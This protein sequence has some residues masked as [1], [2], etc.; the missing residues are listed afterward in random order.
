[1]LICFPVVCQVNILMKRP[2]NVDVDRLIV[3]LERRQRGLVQS[4]DKTFL[5]YLVENV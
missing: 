5:R 2:I 4:I 3:L 1:M